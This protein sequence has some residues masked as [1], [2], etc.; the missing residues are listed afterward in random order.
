MP[1]LPTVAILTTGGTIASRLDPA[2]GAVRPMASGHDLLAA[3]PQAASVA[4]VEVHEFCAV[5]SWNMSPTLM[6]ELAQHL[7]GVLARPDIAGAVVTH[8]TDTVEETAS[9]VD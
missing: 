2:T 1:G 3:L 7:E 6:F 5:P 9:L 4:E 8:G